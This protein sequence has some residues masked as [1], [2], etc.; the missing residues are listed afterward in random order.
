MKRILFFVLIVF[1]L[2]A[3]ASRRYFD[4]NQLTFGMTTEEVISMS[5]RPYRVLVARQT[6]DGYQ[7]V[8]EYHTRYGE[9]YALEFW[10]N[11]LSGFEYLYDNVVYVAPVRPPMVFPHYGSPIVIIHNNNRPGRPN[12]QSNRPN[13]RPTQSTRPSQ[14]NRPT[15]TNK[16][17]ENS[18]PT[19]ST[20]PS[21]L[22]RPNQSVQPNQSSRPTQSTRP[23]ASNNPEYTTQPAESNKPAQSARPTESNR[24]TQSTR[25]SE[26]TQ[27]KESTQQETTTNS[28]R[29]GSS[30]NSSR[31]N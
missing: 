24:A 2:S 10:N 28:S 26:S 22:N 14:Q 6:M 15:Q 21:D 8:L 30:A 23:S 11:Y 7:E 27:S 29:S 17:S 18:R 19:Q 20:R 5:G 3:C 13:N 1:I 4:L 9:V 16:P 31:R 25:S 12:N